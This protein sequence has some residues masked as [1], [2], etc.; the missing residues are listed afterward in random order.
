MNCENREIP[1][2]DLDTLLLFLVGEA[3]GDLRR[4]LAEASCLDLDFLERTSIGTVF[5]RDLFPLE[6]RV[7]PR[8]LDTEMDEE[9]CLP[10][11][12][13]RRF[14]DVRLCEAL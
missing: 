8:F 3:L 9:L 13:T 14:F 10:L 11:A 5:F 12:F 4:T 2:L 6:P 7:D 1:L